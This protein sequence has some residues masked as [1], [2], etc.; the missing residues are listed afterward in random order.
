MPRT[1]ETRKR[2]AQAEL[3][4][5]ERRRRV[6]QLKLQGL[7]F[8]QISR[9]M[10]YKNKSTAYRIWA[11]AMAD[12]PKIPQDLMRKQYEQRTDRA[13]RK[14]FDTMDSPKATLKD[15]LQAAQLVNEI[16]SARAK[17]LGFT[18]PAQVRHGGV[19]G[20]PPVT[21]AAV[22]Y[23]DIAGMTDADLTEAGEALARFA[24]A[25]TGAA[26]A[27]GSEPG[28]GTAEAEGDDGG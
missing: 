1:V 18:E 10:G 8:E 6:S 20:A 24:Q 22:A 3:D 26:P 21:F 9:H 23:G 19:R 5:M 11:K 4:R 16:E 28:D 17:V 7:T 12:V 15:Q 14:A 2:D 27:A 13:L 25:A